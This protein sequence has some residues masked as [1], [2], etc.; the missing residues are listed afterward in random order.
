[1]EQEIF[2]QLKTLE[3]MQYMAIS[4]GIRKSYILVPINKIEELEQIT[5]KNQVT[6]IQ[7]DLV[8][9][10]FNRPV[11]ILHTCGFM[12]HSHSSKNN[13]T[14]IW[15]K[16]DEWYK[17]CKVVATSIDRNKKIK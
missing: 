6:L 3:P 11:D 16:D 7:D 1:M 4:R 14:V 17:E 5:F 13:R 9:I 12:V 8:L 2:N 15:F 10:E